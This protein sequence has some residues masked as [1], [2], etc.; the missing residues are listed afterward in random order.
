M[1]VG[2][3]R[4]CFEIMRH[5]L[6]CSIW[7][8]FWGHVNGAVED[9]GGRLLERERE[10]ARECNVL[11]RGFLTDRIKYMEFTQVTETGFE[12]AKSSPIS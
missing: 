7:V 12:F 9:E 8:F 3:I 2:F 5:R 4:A 11:A 1:D 6:R 10:R